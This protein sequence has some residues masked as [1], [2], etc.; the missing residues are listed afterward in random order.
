MIRAITV[1]I[2]LF[3]AALPALADSPPGGDVLRPKREGPSEFRW[4]LGLDGGLTWSTFQ[5]GPA[6]I[7]APNP[8]FEHHPYPS[9][10][11]DISWVAFDVNSG[12]GFGFSFAGVVDLGF[13]PYFGL[14]GKVNYHTR[15]GSFDQTAATTTDVLIDGSWVPMTISYR[16]AH[17]W[18]LNF[19]GFDLLARIQLAP[20]SWY[21]L[22]GPSFGSLSKNSFEYQKTILSPS[23]VYFLEES[24]LGGLGTPNQLTRMSGT[25]EVT[26]LEKTRVDLKGG[27]G[28]WI[29]LSSQM[30]LTPEVTIA[31]PLTKL[32]SDMDY[33]MI[34]IFATVGL[35]WQMN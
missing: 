18:T 20:E 9:A 27:F 6:S 14:V 13:T 15:S 12:S 19:I 26:N 4:Y 32:H 34:T 22:V 2:S 11:Q 29:P 10:T 25:W 5:K 33:N 16:D 1:I 21:I 28:V 24:T 17:D 30:F 23:D 3:L 35:R 7:L 8:F 31:Y